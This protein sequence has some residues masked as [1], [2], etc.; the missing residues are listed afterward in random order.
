MAQGEQ[1]SRFYYRFFCKLSCHVGG[2][3][4]LAKIQSGAGVVRSH[5][6]MMVLALSLSAYSASKA[7]HFLFKC[8]AAVNF[9]ALRRCRGTYLARLRARVE[10]F[11]RIVFVEFFYSA[12]HTYLAFHIA[13]K[14]NKRPQRVFADLFTLAA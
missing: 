7:A 13:P 9:L 6:N 11:V 5:P 3:G 14:E 4:G 10:I 12:F 1:F 2:C 8:F